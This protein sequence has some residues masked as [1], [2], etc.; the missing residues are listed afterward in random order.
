MS[1]SLHLYQ[2]VGLNEKFPP[3]LKYTT[4]SFMLLSIFRC[5]YTPYTFFNRKN[6]K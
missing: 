3:L 2:L 1:M 6:V 4:L 5:T